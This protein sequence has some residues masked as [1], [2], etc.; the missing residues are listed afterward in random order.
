MSTNLGSKHNQLAPELCRGLGGV[1]YNILWEHH[2]IAQRDA[3]LVI[4][5]CIGRGNMFAKLNSGKLRCP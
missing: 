3:S 2:G 4:L 5:R 1:I